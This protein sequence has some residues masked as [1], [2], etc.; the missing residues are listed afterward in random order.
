MKKRH[1]RNIQDRVDHKRKTK[2]P[3]YNS[4]FQKEKAI[5]QT[6]TSIATPKKTETTRSTTI[7][8]QPSALLCRFKN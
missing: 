4:T 3:F 7:S 1:Q 2:K 6:K 8:K 5:K